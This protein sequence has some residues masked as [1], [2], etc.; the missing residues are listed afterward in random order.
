VSKKTSRHE[1][2]IQKKLYTLFPKYIPKPLG[3]YKGGIM[4]SKKC[5][6]SLK[7]WMSSRACI[8]TRL[9]NQ[10]TRNVRLILEK[11]RRR[12]PGFRHMDLHIGNVLFNKGR[13]MIIDFGLS[14]M[15]APKVCPCKDMNIF[16]KSMRK[17]LKR[18]KGQRKVGEES[19]A[20]IAKRLTQR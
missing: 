9:V 10:I 12:Y 2:T 5:G 3:Y 14:K 17:F 6:V 18:R 19:A 7:K 15:N 8:S 1:Y 4:K 11:I 20:S 13:I 16:I